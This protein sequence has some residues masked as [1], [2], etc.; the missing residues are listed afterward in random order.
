MAAA[1]GKVARYLHAELVA[2][3]AGLD[4]RWR[5][6]RQRLREDAQFD[7]LY[8]LLTNQPRAAAGRRA[9]FRAY[10]DQSAVEG[11]FRVLKQPPL[12]VRPLWL[13][14]PRR[15]ESLVFVVLVALFLFALIEREARRV[16][17]ASGQPFAGVRAEGRD[18][19]PITAACLLELFAP[20]TV[21]KQQ[22][23]LAGAVIDL[24]TPATLSPPQAQVL[25]RLGL[26]RPNEYLHASVTCHPAEGCGK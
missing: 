13:H 19:L 11:R 14:Q 22:L 26:P 21:V 18:K 8:C 23:R 2:S 15:L 3:T 1:V 20:L 5:L 17:R 16:V 4:V 10:K 24:V 9:V 12:Q 25:A 6:D 7:G